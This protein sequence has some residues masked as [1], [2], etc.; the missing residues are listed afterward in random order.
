[1][2]LGLLFFIFGGKVSEVNVSKL[3]SPQG[4]SQ[5]N[6]FNL[7]ICCTGRTDAIT[8]LAGVNLTEAIWVSSKRCI[9]ALDSFVLH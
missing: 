5:S 7:E 8:N 2:P 4:E 6:I 1:M 9:T 3:R